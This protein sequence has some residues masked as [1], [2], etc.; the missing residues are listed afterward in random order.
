MFPFLCCSVECTILL[1]CMASASVKAMDVRT[2]AVS[3]WI[4][5]RYRNTGI[6]TN[7][8]CSRMQR[9][10]AS[11][12]FEKSLIASPD[13]LQRPVSQALLSQVQPTVS[14]ISSLDSVYQGHHHR[15]RIKE[16]LTLKINLNVLRYRQLLH[17]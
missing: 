2:G 4:Q 8:E 6:R 11:V 5:E 17:A 7:C 14:A 1:E 13:T 15:P 9:M 12:L 16:A 10:I 3:S